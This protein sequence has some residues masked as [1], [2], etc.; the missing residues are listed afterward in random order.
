MGITGELAGF[1][2]GVRL[3]NLPADVVTRA[4]FLLLDLVGN[5]VRARHDADSTHSFLAAARA[6]GMGAGNNGVSAAQPATLPPA[7]HS[8]MGPLATRL[9][10]TTPTP[11]PR[12]T[13][14]RR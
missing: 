11:L 12:S 8:S 10:S 5:I 3:E 13:Q 2:A 14:V 6:L 1:S 9:T 4:R 7:P